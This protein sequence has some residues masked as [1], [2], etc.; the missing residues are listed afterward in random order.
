ME[1]FGTW[2]SLTNHYENLSP[3]HAILP[4][5]CTGHLRPSTKDELLHPIQQPYYITLLTP[6]GTFWSYKTG[7]RIEYVYRPYL[8]N[9]VISDL[10][11][12]LS[13]IG[14][15]T[16]HKH[17]DESA[18][19]N[20]G[21][22]KSGKKH[23]RASNVKKNVECSTNAHGSDADNCSLQLEQSAAKKKTTKKSATN[24]S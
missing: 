11:P 10:Y 22:S 7:S 4:S 3:K 16:T 12:K 20:N 17:S 6:V 8:H 2:F 5:W 13:G 19:S 1:N 14:K 24:V 21:T 23:V 15:S 18:V 9:D